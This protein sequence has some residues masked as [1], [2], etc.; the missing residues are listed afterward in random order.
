[1]TFMVVFHETFCFQ[2]PKGWDKLYV[3]LLSS[4]TGKTNSKSGKAPV[5]NGNC[6]WT[7]TLSE[8]IWISK[9]EASK[10]LHQCFFKLVVAMVGCL[11]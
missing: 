4:E 10:E 9:D 3:S 5:R 8:T 1:M 7:E 2:V 11:F 6:K